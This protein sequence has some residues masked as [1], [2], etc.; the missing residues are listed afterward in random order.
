[1]I[2][3]KSISY[4][5]IV[6]CLLSLLPIVDSINGV[7]I[8]TNMPSVGSL[9]KVCVMGIMLIMILSNG[10]GISKQFGI[11]LVA[12]I[13]IFMSIFINY[14]IG[15]GG[16]ISIDYPIKLIINII[17]FYV[18]LQ[19]IK[20]KH[21]NGNTIYKILNNNVYVIILCI[22]VPYLLGMG[23]TIYAG[24]LGYK[25][26]YYSQNELNAILIIL[27]FFA[28]HKLSK[29]IKLWSIIQVIGILICILLMST[30]SSLIAIIIGIGIFAFEYMRKEN[31]RKKIVLLGMISVG[32]LLVSGFII[33]KIMDMITRQNSLHSIY[34]GSLLAT[35]TSGRI[36]RLEKAW[37]QL[38]ESD[39]FI[40]NMFIGNG[41]F[42]KCLV[43]MDFF[44]IFFYLGIIGVFFVFAFLMYVIIKGKKA[45]KNDKNFII[46]TG[47]FVIIAFAFLTGHVLF[48]SSS[49]WYFVLYCIY[50]MTYDFNAIE[51]KTEKLGL[52]GE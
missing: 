44:D 9:Y 15:N 50:I 16:I 20:N 19:N 27:L 28:L 8:Y 25:G 38:I 17:L 37:E 29:K 39:N 35:L 47:L 3:K 11:I 41:F 10:K 2:K 13:Y 52:I 40:I 12:I 14:V 33:R 6:I 24:N 31:A 21:I 5:A 4:E 7:L 42:S 51:D 23:Y 32:T 26:F 48:M 22:V 49:G 30:K 46:I 1:M 34:K 45:S 36:F 18:L 43:E